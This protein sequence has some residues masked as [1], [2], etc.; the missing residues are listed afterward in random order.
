MANR[1]DD[2]QFI[3]LNENKMSNKKTKKQNEKKLRKND[4]VIFNSLWIL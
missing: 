4:F 2:F 3:R 1:N